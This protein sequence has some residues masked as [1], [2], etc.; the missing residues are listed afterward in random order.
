MTQAIYWLGLVSTVLMVR[1]PSQRSSKDAGADPR[2]LRFPQQVSKRELRQEGEA[3][4]LFRDPK[5]LL[6]RPGEVVVTANRIKLA[7]LVT[8]SSARPFPLVVHPYGGAFPYGGDNP[9]V[10]RFAG[11][12]AVKYTGKRYPPEPPLPMLIE[13]PG[14]SCV[15]FEAEIDLRNYTYHGSPQVIVEWSFYYF[16]GKYPEGQMQVRLPAPGA[17]ATPTGHSEF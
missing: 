11:Q 17:G 13:M 10:L 1:P 7:V 3:E 6:V 9:L 16:R 5:P 2:V 14:L 8:N 15:Q 4:R 12:A